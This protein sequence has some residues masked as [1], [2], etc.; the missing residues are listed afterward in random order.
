MNN[1]GELESRDL[2]EAIHLMKVDDEIDFIK[3]AVVYYME[4]ISK[5]NERKGLEFTPLN[6]LNVL[7]MLKKTKK[8]LEIIND[9]VSKNLRLK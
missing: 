4:S 8:I 5:K 1:K 2:N 3:N 7:F 6:F 9:K